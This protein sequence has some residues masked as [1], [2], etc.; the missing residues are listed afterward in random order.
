MTEV[1]AAKLYDAYIQTDHDD[2]D[3]AEA[4]SV[5]TN[6]QK[7]ARRVSKRPSIDHLQDATVTI[8]GGVVV[9]LF[10]IGDKIVAERYCSFLNG[11]PWLDT[12]IYLV[13]GIDDLKGLAKCWDEDSQQNVIIGFNHPSTK[14][15]LCPKKGNPFHDPSNPEKTIRR[16]RKKVTKK[17]GRK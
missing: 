8:E 9:P 10:N 15:K 3:E 5:L 1:A 6:E 7:E 12:K 17:R 4:R 2:V 14:V 16:R 11:N 13:K